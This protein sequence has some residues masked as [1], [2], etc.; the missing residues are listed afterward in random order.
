VISSSQQRDVA[1]ERRSDRC[2]CAQV[3][4]RRCAHVRR[5]RPG[6]SLRA[7]GA[8]LARPEHVTTNYRR[9]AGAILR[10]LRRFRA[11]AAVVYR[12]SRAVST[13][14]VSAF[15]FGR[16]AFDRARCD[17]SRS[18]TCPRRRVGVRQGSRGW[19][20]ENA[21]YL[22]V[23]APVGGVRSLASRRSARGQTMTPRTRSTGS[24]GSSG[25]TQVAPAVGD[26]SGE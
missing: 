20:P 15:P 13:S 4:A 14:D 25:P 19:A 24:V 22:R 9:F 2:I 21:E 18:W 5:V 26:V 17:V 11:V 6:H 10:L 1:A 3:A 16:W 7:T 8:H 12:F 23:H